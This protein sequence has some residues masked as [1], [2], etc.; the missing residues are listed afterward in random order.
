MKT[1]LKRHGH[2]KHI[3]HNEKQEQTIQTTNKRE[4][5]E[6]QTLGNHESQW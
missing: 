2:T 6:T 3:E 4:H 1:K 5:L